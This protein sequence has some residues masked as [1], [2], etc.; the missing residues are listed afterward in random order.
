MAPGGGDLRASPASTNTRSP[1]AGPDPEVIIDG[2]REA[3]TA[4]C[5]GRRRGLPFA[6]AIAFSNGD[7]HGMGLGFIE[8]RTAAGDEGAMIRGAGGMTCVYPDD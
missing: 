3:R 4:T 1:T 6:G 8:F 5:S 7:K 2:R